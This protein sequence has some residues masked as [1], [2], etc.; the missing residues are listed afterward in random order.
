M[1]SLTFE[2]IKKS[3]RSKARR[4]RITT[5]HSV[6]E[7][8]VFMPVGT[9]ATVKAMK[10][11][12][13]RDMGA[14]I[15]LGNTY[16]LF[17]RP[18]H[19]LI[20]EAGGLHTFMNWSGSI[21]TDSGGFQ[22]FSLGK[23]RK[24]TEE[25]VK[26]QSYLDGSRHMLTPESVVEIQTALGS[27]IMMAFDECAPYPADRRY[28]KDSLERTTRWLKRCKEAHWNTE[29][30]AL[31]GIMQGG[32]Y[33]D[34]R[35]ESADQIVEMDLPGY[36]I[37]GLSVGEPK[38]IMYDMLDDCVDWL[39]EEKPRY[40]MGVGSPDCLLEGVARGIDMF[41]CV[42]P[43]RIA[44]NGMAYT[45]FG[46][47]SIKNKQ[48]EKDFGP[49]DPKCDCYT[50]RNY[51][52]AYLRHLFKAGEILSSILLTHHNIYY[53]LNL[54]KEVRQAIEEDRFEEYRLDFYHETG[55]TWK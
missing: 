51:S 45:S 49:L 43:T 42:I 13:V 14:D 39:P 16:H 38:E 52:R 31:F 21:L 15:I 30:Q 4:G 19:E 26:F 9:Q 28:I 22:V 25:G 27:D 37:G 5:R 2:L 54:M 24:I 17:L 10:P 12:E 7:T 18:G 40:L 3:S 44:R 29:E 53:L 11:E 34:M 41:D 50:C 47:V 1:A 46:K 36:S 23:M 33:K 8:P 35:K 32:M 55:D 20:R 6:I 48:Y